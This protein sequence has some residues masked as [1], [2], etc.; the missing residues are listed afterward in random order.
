MCIKI[1]VFWSAAFKF[2]YFTLF[3]LWSSNSDEV[4]SLKDLNKI[5]KAK[6]YY[7]FIIFVLTGSGIR[8]TLSCKLWS[9]RGL[10]G[11]LKMFHERSGEQEEFRKGMIMLSPWFQN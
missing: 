10:R 9:I 3:L 5:E 6:I 7:F 8:E 4:V 1:N 11:L 2:V